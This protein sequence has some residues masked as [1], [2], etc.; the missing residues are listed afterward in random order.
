MKEEADEWG[1]F[2]SQITEAEHQ[3]KQVTLNK[4]VRGGSKKFYVYTKKCVHCRFLKFWSNCCHSQFCSS[5]QHLKFARHLASWQL[6]SFLAPANPL[7]VVIW[8]F[9]PDVLSTFAV[10]QFCTSFPLFAV[11]L[12]WRGCQS[13]QLCRS[14]KVVLVRLCFLS[15]GLSV[16]GPEH[17]APV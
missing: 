1:I 12:F 6:C 15:P 16:L 14:L 10:C 2:P 9:V 4:P 8:C 7:G 5:R 11:H 3:G 13:L 17:Q